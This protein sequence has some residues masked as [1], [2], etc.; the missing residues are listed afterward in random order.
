MPS[1][2]VVLARSPQ[3]RAPSGQCHRLAFCGLLPLHLNSAL[4]V[5]LGVPRAFKPS[6]R[7]SLGFGGRTDFAETT[8]PM[9]CGSASEPVLCRGNRSLSL[10]LGAVLPGEGGPGW[11]TSL[12][13]PVVCSRTSPGSLLEMQTLSPHPRDPQVTPALTEIR[14]VPK[15]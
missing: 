5:S 14:E 12:P 6:Q 10:G 7:K 13:L 15:S 1:P 9:S 11:G 8:E 4:P 3:L 2:R